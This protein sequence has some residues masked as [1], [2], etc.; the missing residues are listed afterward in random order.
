ATRW[1]HDDTMMVTAIT[2]LDRK[3][4]HLRRNGEVLLRAH[5]GRVDDERAN[6]LDDQELTLRV[7]DELRVLLGQ[8]GPRRAS[9]V[10]R[11]PRALPQYHVGHEQLV[12]DARKASAA[13]RVALAGMAYDG[14][15]I[16]AS[17]GSGRRAARDVQSMLA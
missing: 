10:Q 15:G 11:W 8:L 1:A 16:P 2:L 6:E 12:A 7:S 3:W 14:V 17:I 9:L 5:V 4:P 13:L